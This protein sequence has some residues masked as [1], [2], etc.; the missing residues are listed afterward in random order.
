V[1]R[2]HDVFV[3]FLNG[4]G[5]LLLIVYLVFFNTKLKRTEANKAAEKENISGA[6]LTHL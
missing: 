1:A 3:A 4:Y 6:V 5:L 2:N